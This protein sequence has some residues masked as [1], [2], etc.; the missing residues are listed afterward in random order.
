MTGAALS[1]QRGWCTFEVC[2][3]DYAV[4]VASV[5]EV[6]RAQ[7]LTRV[8]GAP[9]AW[10]GLL[11]LRGRI[12]PAVDLRVLFGVAPE[13]APAAGGALVVVRSGEGPLALGVDAIG[14]VHR[15]ADTRLEPWPEAGGERGGP[16]AALFAG[17]LAAAERLIGVLDL[18]RVVERAF[19]RPAS[20]SRRTPGDPS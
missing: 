10:T 8:P 7:P 18:E 3:R 4:D 19:E 9:P 6:L 2:G 14:D 1:T 12:V 15:G 5:Q 17:V 11:N 13:R 20:A 16:D